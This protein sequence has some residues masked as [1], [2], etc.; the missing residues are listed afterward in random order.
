MAAVRMTTEAVTGQPREGRDLTTL[1]AELDDT[2]RDAIRRA[3]SRAEHVRL[4]R[5]QSLVAALVRMNGSGG[6][7][8]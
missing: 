5:I 7:S 6:T 8:D 1:A 4:V 2:V 3:S